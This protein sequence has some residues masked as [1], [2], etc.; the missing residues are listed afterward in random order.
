MGSNREDPN[1]QSTTAHLCLLAEFALLFKKTLSRSLSAQMMTMRVF[2][3]VCCPLISE[4]KVLRTPGDK[5]LVSPRPRQAPPS[6]LFSYLMAAVIP[7]GVIGNGRT[8]GNSPRLRT[9]AP[10]CITP[11]ETRKAKEKKD[12]RGEFKC[13]E[14]SNFEREKGGAEHVCEQVSAHT[15][16]EGKGYRDQDGKTVCKQSHQ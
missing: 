14:V 6:K 8:P 5:G 7:M 2:E 10:F 9:L 16:T 12:I 13:Q 3:R 11:G 4:N 1:A 15:H